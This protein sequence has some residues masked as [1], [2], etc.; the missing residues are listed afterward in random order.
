[1]NRMKDLENLEPIPITDAEI[2][3]PRLTVSTFGKKNTIKSVCFFLILAIFPLFFIKF[4][5]CKIKVLAVERKQIQIIGEQPSNKYMFFIE[6]FGYFND[7]LIISFRVFSADLRGYK[8]PMK[9]TKTQTLLNWKETAPK[10]K[11]NFVF[12][13]ESTPVTFFS[14]YLSNTRSMKIVAEFDKNI[15]M[16]SSVQCFVE[17]TPRAMI[18]YENIVRSGFAVIVFILFF[19]FTDSVEKNGLL[20]PAQFITQ[21]YLVPILICNIPVDMFRVIFNTKLVRVVK[22]VFDVTSTGTVLAIEVWLVMMLT[23]RES[24]PQ[25]RE[26]MLTFI[27][28]A[29][30]F[31]INLFYTLRQTLFS[32]ELS[33]D[34]RLNYVYKWFAMLVICIYT[35]WV[36]SAQDSDDPNTGRAY[37]SFVALMNAVMLITDAFE[38][39]ESH[40]INSGISISLKLS[41]RFAMAIFLSYLHWPIDKHYFINNENNKKEEKKR[42]QYTKYVDKRNV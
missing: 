19:V 18:S 6:N 41:S 14:E 4:V 32:R 25:Y 22:S 1:M 7:F 12:T 24:K 31:V 10:S 16:V 39:L 17:Y 37:M 3:F 9:V 36:V 5:P 38:I 20:Y 26:T 15:S 35:A 40:Y 23:K 28:V 34:Y 2:E 8:V 30:S 29:I 27:I 42:S 11:T 21:F 13:N 33:L